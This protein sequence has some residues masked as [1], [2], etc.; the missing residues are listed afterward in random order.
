[1][2]VEDIISK[3]RKQAHS[4]HTSPLCI[5]LRNFSFSVFNKKFKNNKAIF[6]I[7]TPL[8]FKICI[9]SE[10]VAKNQRFRKWISTHKSLRSPTL[11]CNLF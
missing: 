8:P 1:M 4:S 5:R 9:T 11:T 6:F 7:Q 2:D 10:W 3:N